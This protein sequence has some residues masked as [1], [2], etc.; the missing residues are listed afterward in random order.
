ME[1]RRQAGTCYAERPDGL[2][3]GCMTRWGEGGPYRSNTR[4][5]PRSAE[6]PRLDGTRKWLCESARRNPW[7]LLKT[8]VPTAVQL[9]GLPFYKYNRHRPA[10]WPGAWVGVDARARRVALV[11][12]CACKRN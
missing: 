8:S 7:L 1:T 3:T 2:Q 12:P 4:K 11:S 10:E 9:G 5:G 6:N